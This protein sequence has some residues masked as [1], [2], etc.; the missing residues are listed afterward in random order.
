MLHLVPV[1]R[2]VVV[3]ETENCG[4]HCVLDDEAGRGRDRAVMGE[5]DVEQGA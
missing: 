5:Q 2:L 1:V 4:V 3:D